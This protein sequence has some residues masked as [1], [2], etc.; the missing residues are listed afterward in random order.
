MLENPVHAGHRPVRR[1]MQRG[2]P[3]VLP[4]QYNAETAGAAFA[5]QLRHHVGL[6]VN[7]QHLISVVYQAFQP[8][9][10]AMYLIR[11]PDPIRRNSDGRAD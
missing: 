5:V 7:Q 8:T 10:V 2:R 9:Q 11:E 3:P 1:R 4:V 6:D